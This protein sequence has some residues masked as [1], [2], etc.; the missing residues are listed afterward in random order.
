MSRIETKYLIIGNSTA[1]VACIEGIRIEDEIGDITLISAEPEHTYSRPLIS[2]LLGGEIQERQMYY[3]PTDFYEKNNVRPILGNSV[4]RIAESKKIIY[5]EKGEQIHFEK[6]LIATGGAPIVPDIPGV[7]SEGVF[8]FLTWQDS[9][10]I[11]KYI[12]NRKAHKAIVV[13]AGLIGVKA[14]EAL[15]AL[16]LKVDVIEL[17]EHALST[18]LDESGAELV[19]QKMESEGV[20]LHCGTT[21]SEVQTQYDVVSGVRLSNGLRLDCDLVIFAIG[22]RPNIAMIKD[23]SIRAERGILVDERMRTNIPDIFAAGDVAQGFDFLLG[24]RRPLAIFPNA[25]QQGRIA[26]INMAGG[27]QTFTGG[28]AMN[29][30]SVCGLPVISV[31][32][33]HPPDDTCEVLSKRDPLKSTYKKVILKD[34]QIIGAIFINEIDRAGIYTGLIRSKLDISEIRDLLMTN[35]F[36]LITLPRHYRKHVVSGMGIE[37]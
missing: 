20:A 30:V 8:S 7:K 22:V 17:A 11:K 23:T 28:M 5:T 6:L 27:E 16:H 29:S 2:Y 18:M 14:M 1:A 21:V 26:G 34:N 33:I 3:R 25:Y 19:H 4:T 35:G 36:G 9:I 37:I 15:L 10:R 24:E 12:Q 13:G 31:G 32:Y